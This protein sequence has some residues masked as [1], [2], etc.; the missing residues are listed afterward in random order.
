MPRKPLPMDQ[1]DH[2]EFKC[3]A[4]KKQVCHLIYTDNTGDKVEIDDEIVDVYKVD[5]RE[6]IQLKCG[7]TLPANKVIS[8]N[9]KLISS[10]AK[11]EEFN[12]PI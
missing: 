12:M 11:H 10:E 7:L 5:E 9:G 3:A 2:D 1:E 8:L 6:M 4:Q